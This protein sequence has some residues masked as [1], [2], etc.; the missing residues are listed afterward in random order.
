MRSGSHPA[1]H[2]S[3]DIE[4]VDIIVDDGYSAKSSGTTGDQAGAAL[5][6]AK[7]A[8]AIVVASSSIA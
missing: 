3:Q 6:T 4:L 8:D 2:V 1:H 5:L 7:G